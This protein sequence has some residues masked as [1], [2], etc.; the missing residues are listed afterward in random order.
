MIGLNFVYEKDE[1][2]YSLDVHVEVGEQFSLDYLDF[3]NQSFEDVI[4]YMESL[5]FEQ[6][7]FVALEENV[8]LKRLVTYLS[9]KVTYPIGI[10]EW[11]D[12]EKLL[13]SEKITSLQKTLENHNV[14]KKLTELNTEVVLKNGY[15][16]FRSAVYPNLTKGLLKHLLVDQLDEF[17]N[18]NKELLLH[19]AVNSAIYSDEQSNSSNIPT[20]IKSL[21][22]FKDEIFDEITT[23]KLKNTIDYFLNSGQVTLKNKVLDYGIL[24]GMSKFNS[25]IF[26]GGQFYLDSAANILIGYSGETYQ[27]LFNEASMKL[28]KQG[29]E[30]LPEISYLFF[31]LIAISQQ[32]SNMEFVTPYNNYYIPGVAPNTVPLGWIAFKNLNNCFAYNLQ[33]GRLFKINQLVFEQL[34]YI[35]KEQLPE[36]DTVTQGVMEVLKSYAK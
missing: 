1:L 35:I 25:L 9:N 31:M 27:K 20:I 24:M 19:F 22:D 26:K 13:P 28:N 7:Y 30:I 2:L 4:D 15:R 21:A 8:R 16:A 36:N 12:F 11:N 14:Y 3:D 18:D 32:Y 6:Y 10:I 23:N 33:N 29:T 34:E 5:E 17:L